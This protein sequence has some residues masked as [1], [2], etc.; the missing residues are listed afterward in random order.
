MIFHCVV[1]LDAY[2]DRFKCSCGEVFTCTVGWAWC[3]KDGTWAAL[4]AVEPTA[5]S[6]RTDPKGDT[7]AMQTITRDQLAEV[8]DGFWF[9]QQ[10]GSE[11][12]AD[13]IWE[14]AE[15]LFSPPDVCNA[16]NLEGTAPNPDPDPY[17]YFAVINDGRLA[18]GVRHGPFGTYEGALN[19]KKPHWFTSYAGG[20]EGVGWHVSAVRTQ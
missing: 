1:P 3:P 17:I 14:S 16:E 6:A 18:S 12:T 7:H 20:P 11:R 5:D 15:A 19:S 4:P 13:D 2:D 8:L 10:V 9:A